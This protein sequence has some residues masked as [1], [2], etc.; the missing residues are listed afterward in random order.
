MRLLPAK[1]LANM[2]VLFTVADSYRIT[3]LEWWLAG[4]TFLIG[5]GMA[6][7]WVR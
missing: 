2:P 6:L 7:S 5:T 1:E 4:L 3:R